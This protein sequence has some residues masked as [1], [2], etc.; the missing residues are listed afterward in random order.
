MQEDEDD[1]YEE[2]HLGEQ[3]QNEPKKT[4]V[5]ESSAFIARLKQGSV[6][7]SRCHRCQMNL[8]SLVGM[9][10]HHHFLACEP[11][12]GFALNSLVG[13]SL[14]FYSPLEKDSSE[15]DS[16]EEERQILLFETL[17]II[18]VSFHSLHTLETC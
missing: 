4:A 10:R 2:H 18:F 14:W 3:V 12:V 16:E 9:R 1:E 6:G 15:E 7:W 13:V 8:K 17:S 11:G 5:A